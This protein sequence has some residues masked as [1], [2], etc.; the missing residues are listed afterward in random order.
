M[1][2]EATETQRQ[3]P[4]SQ[5]GDVMMALAGAEDREQI[6]QVAHSVSEV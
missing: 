5:E 4:Y 3:T 2:Q 1:D 6:A